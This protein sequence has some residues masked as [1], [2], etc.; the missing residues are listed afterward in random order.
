MLRDLFT[1]YTLFL[2]ILPNLLHGSDAFLQEKKALTG[3]EIVSYIETYQRKMVST[4][5]QMI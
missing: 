2:P 4:L 3:L 5:S 1:L